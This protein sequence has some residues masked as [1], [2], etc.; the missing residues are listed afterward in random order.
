[1]RLSMGLIKADIAVL[2][3][4]LLA[5]L[6]PRTAL[7]N[8]VF[9][10]EGTDYWNVTPLSTEKEFPVQTQNW[11]TGPDGREY[12]YLNGVLKTDYITSDNHYFNKYFKF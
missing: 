11:R 8:H 7:A 4:L 2:A 10:P 3:G 12:Y 9:F 5:L 6:C 1:M